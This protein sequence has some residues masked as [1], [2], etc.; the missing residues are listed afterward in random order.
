MPSSGGEY[1][2]PSNLTA[3][4]FG[5]VNVRPGAGGLVVDFTILME[6]EGNEAEGWQ[7]GVALDA[8]ASMKPWYGQ[9]LDGKVPKE[10]MAEYQQRGWV[11]SR[12]EDGKTITFLTP[13]AYNDAMRRGHLQRSQ[14]IVQ[15]I[16]REFLAYLAGNLDAD[17]GTT[18]IYWAC[19]R[20]EALEVVGDV[21]EEQ[22]V[23]LEVKGPAKAG[24]GAGTMLRPAVEYFTDRFSDAKR[25]M[26]VFI[27]DGRLD[28]LESVKALTTRL[29]KEIAAG[30]RNPVKCVLIGV[31]NHVDEAQMEELD[32]LE[33]GTNVDIWDH[34]IAVDM[35]ALVEIF[36]EVVSESQIVAPSGAVFDS[37]GNNIKSYRD[38]LPAKA[39]V[40][41]SPGSQWFELEVG[42]RR[43]RQTLVVVNS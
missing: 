17:G 33:T 20:G 27:T 16:A 25:G 26:Y 9:S 6:P 1:T 5:K 18:V 19:G 30:R 8:S 34:K 40:T 38:G 36:S 31:G 28:D 32:G 14:N 22:C 42:G 13:D 41:L 3:A 12:S 4:E 23:N 24:F 29:A 35:R 11:N 37:A 21:T 15:P 2:I 43:I 7:T 10:V 39:E